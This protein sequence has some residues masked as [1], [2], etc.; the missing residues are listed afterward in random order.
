M[1]LKKQL[2]FL[3]VCQSIPNP[4]LKFSMMMNSVFL[5]VFQPSDYLKNPGKIEDVYYS[6]ERSISKY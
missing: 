2:K 4:V 6:E 1:T 3:W 5:K